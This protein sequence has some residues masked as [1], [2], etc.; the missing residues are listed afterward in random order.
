[1]TKAGRPLQEKVSVMSNNVVDA[2][3]HLC[4]KPIIMTKSALDNTLP[5]EIFTV[6]IDREESKNNTVT[7]LKDNNIPVTWEHSAGVFSLQVQ[8]PAHDITTHVAEKSCPI[9][10]KAQ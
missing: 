4:P 9:A 2:R 8:T 7:F 3:G 10:K 6:L 5:G 1:M